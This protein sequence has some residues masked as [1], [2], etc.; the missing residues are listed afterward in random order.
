MAAAVLF[1]G[2]VLSILF[3]AASALLGAATRAPG[4]V[5]AGQPAVATVAPDL[6]RIFSTAAA[7]CP[8]L[9]WTILA[10]IGE[11]ESGDGS[12]QLP[13]VHWGHNPAGAEGP[14]QFEPATF[15]TYALPVPPGGLDPPSPY[16]LTDAAFAA[17]RLLCAE[18]ASTPAS[19][20]AALYAYN[21]SEAYVAEVLQ[22]AQSYGLGPAGSGRGAGVALDYALGQV[23]TPYRWGGEAPGV[24]FDCS[25]L[26]QAA[27][28]AAGVALP[29]VAQDQ[30]D[31]GPRV[32]PGA[33]LQPGDLVFF[34]PRPGVATHVGLVVDPSGVMVDAPHSGA[35]IRLES[36]PLEVGGGW[37]E[38]IFVGATRPGPTRANVAGGG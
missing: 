22:V 36:F 26:A 10:A 20:G 38:E 4:P 31:A 27:W 25:G 35:S 32:V 15:A 37:G 9:S 6:L 17:A 29:R 7:T 18:G 28:A 21:H 23:G 2:L 5:A 11:V 33:P 16:D 30:F 19:L 24:G 34:G 8:G 14:M 13:G 3:V 1:V 12:S